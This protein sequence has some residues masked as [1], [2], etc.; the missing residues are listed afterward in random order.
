MTQEEAE[1]ILKVNDQQ[2]QKKFEGLEAKAKDLQKKFAEATKLGNVQDVIKINKELQT[3][4]R[5]MDSM[6]INAANIR[7]AMVSI[8]EAAPKDLQRTIKYINSELNSGRVKR[9][10]DEWKYYIERL[11]EVQVELRKVKA[12]MALADDRSLFEKVKDGFNEWAAAAAAAVAALTGLVLSGKSA[13]Q[14]YADMEAEEA[15]V[16]KF[17]GMTAEQVTSLNR[18]FKKMDTR[19]AR[20]ELNKLAQE[21]GRLG[22]QTEE[23]V[24]GYVKAADKIN[25]ALDDIGEGATLTLSKLTGIFGIEDKYGTERS[26]LKVGSVVN[27]LS[28]NCSAS[29]PYLTEFTS[30]LGGIAAQSKISIDQT[31]AY[32][33]VLDTQN[34][35]VEASATAVGQLITKIYKEPAKFAEKTGLEVKKFTDMVKTDMNGALIMLFEHLNKFGGME[36]LA[37]VFDDLGTDGARAIPVLTAL[38]GHIDELKAQQE[39]ANDAFREGISVAKEFNVQNNTVQARIDKAKKRFNELAVS[40]GQKLLPVMQHSISGSSMMLRVLSVI[41]D[42]VI[43]NR[44]AIIGLTA[45]IITYKIAVSGTNM[46]MK[47][48]YYWLIVSEKA[49]NAWKAAVGAVRVVL[50]ALTMGLRQATTAYKELTAAQSTTLW[51]AIAVAVGVAVTAIVNYATKT[52]SATEATNRLKDTLSDTQKSIRDEKK[53]IDALFGKLDAAKKGTQQYEDAKNAIIS[54]YGDYLSGLSQEIQSLEDV[55]AAYKAITEEATNAAKAR[56]LAAAKQNAD[57]AFNKSLGEES[58]NIY[59]ALSDAE[60]TI[61]DGNATIKRKMNEREIIKWQQK[62]LDEATNGGEFSSDVRQFLQSI[63][64]WKTKSGKYNGRGAGDDVADAINSIIEAS[65]AH[66]F[67]LQ[68]AEVTFGTPA[69]NYEGMTYDQLKLVLEDLNK[70]LE[71]GGRDKILPL[72]NGKS[73]YFE[74]SADIANEISALKQFIDKKLDEMDGVEVVGGK[75]KQS[76]DL[77]ES[78]EERKK[79]EKEERERQR[80]AKEALKADLDNAKYAR[81]KAEAENILAYSTGLKNY[82]EYIAEKERIEREYA[83]KLVGIHEQHN[84]IDIA[85][86][87]QALLKREELTKKSADKIEK[88]AM[89]WIDKKYKEDEREA[90]EDFY[91]PN[92]PLFNNQKAL[93]QRLF[94][95]DVNL[96]RDKAQLYEEGSNQRAELERKIN[97]RI[98]KDQLDK[99]KETAEAYIAFER[100]YRKSSGS[101]REKNELDLLKKLLDQKLITEEEYQRAVKKIKQKY[102]DEDEEKFREI[103]SEYFDIVNDLYKKFEVFFANLGQNG[104]DFWKNLSEAAGAAFAF[105]GAALSQYSAY[106]DASRDLEIAKIEK[107]YDAEIEAAGNNSKKAAELEKK[108]DAEIAKIKTAHNEKAMKIEL[109]QAFAQTALS[110]I[111]AYA[112]AQHLPWPMSQIVGGIAAG[113]ATAMGMAQ[114]ATIKKQHE[115]EA[116]GYYSGGFTAKDPDNRR[117]VG[118]VHANEFVA[119]HQAVANPALSPVLRLIDH[120]QRTNTVGY[121]SADDVDIALGRRQGVS[122]RGGSDPQGDNPAAVA[123]AYAAFAES[124]A[125]TREAVDRLTAILADGLKTEMIM[126]GENG[127]HKKYEHY[128]RL[129]SNPKR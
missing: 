91:D 23:E 20:E 11:K 129:I 52:N 31:M 55:A 121:L 8:N 115:A 66:N 19:T 122:V 127:F 1:V 92:G 117:E 49:S 105:I 2:A 50:T 114:I 72:A 46:A 70:L 43:E 34:L 68:Q 94:E 41:V 90:I 44:K 125:A 110:A 35:A 95:L 7:A 87:G 40:L 15:N 88:L 65:K 29:A 80:K 116:A 4:N 97:E 48:H 51:G 112:S 38:A 103:A 83:D 73:M 63:G 120:A 77:P 28:Q 81:D 78:D 3:T 101:D 100:E 36:T 10:S 60:R 113:L 74:D 98:A 64:V 5:Q 82:S 56:G 37:T 104:D 67:E 12:E 16:R 93:N 79:R 71:E 54:Q 26:L 106:A 24:L 53:E 124:N 22:K 99:Q 14:A 17:T 33:A 57:D 75:S 58:K 59:D 45:A 61:K 69:S 25:V 30:R 118:V 86:Y 89:S 76:I 126:D 21:A 6:R 109:A 108:K 62:I 123:V 47:A 13:V 9:G 84:T 85:A 39:A 111:Q 107:R 96:M 102:L 128:K 42:F 18:E 32:A 119:N 27:E